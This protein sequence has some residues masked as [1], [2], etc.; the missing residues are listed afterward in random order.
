MFALVE[1]SGLVGAYAAFQS[2]LRQFFLEQLLQFGLRVRVAASAWVSG[3]ATVAA[4]EDVA[5][6]RRHNSSVKDEREPLAI[7][8]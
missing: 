3:L 5:L 7:G 6:E 2:L 4:N 1:A 8:R